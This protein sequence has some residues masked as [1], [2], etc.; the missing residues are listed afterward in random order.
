MTIRR[1]ED[2]ETWLADC[3]AQK[4]GE[5]REGKHLTDSVMCNIKGFAAARLTAAGLD[6]PKPNAGALIRMAIGIGL[7]QVIEEGHV[8]Q[9]QTI[10]ADDDSIGT[11][12]IWWRRRVVEIKVTWQSSNKRP[13]DNAHWLEQTGGYVARNLAAAAGMGKAEFWVVHLGG[14]G[15]AMYCPAHGRPENKVTRLNEGTGRQRMVCPEC[16]EFLV[17]GNREPEIRCWEKTWPAEELRSLHAI[18]TARQAELAEDI[19]NPAYQI[20]GELPPIRW[21]LQAEFECKGCIFKERIGCPGVGEANDLADA[22]EGSINVV[23]EKEGAT[24]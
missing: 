22:L 7:G 3:L 15:G 8:A 14:D 1:L 16:R 10:S 21:G 23:Q 13:E 4:V 17:P 2:R 11:I 20:G 19:A 12:D 6:L 24:A 18:Q 5:R 9:I